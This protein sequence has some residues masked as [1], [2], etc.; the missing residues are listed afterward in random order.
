MFGTFKGKITYCAKTDRGL[1]YNVN[2]DAIAAFTQGSLG[3]F[4][5]SDGMGGHSMGELAS[6]CIALQ[7][8]NYWQQLMS[9]PQLPDFATLTWQVQQVLLQANQMIYAQYNQGQVC[10]ATAVVLLIWEDC[11]AVLSV[12]DSHIYS[13]MDKSLRPLSVDD[14]WDLLPS[15]IS[16]FTPEQ[17]ALHQSRGKLVQAV[18]TKP[19]INIH[20]SSDR[21]KK[22]Q[23]FLLCSDG[24]Y[25]FCDDKQ[26]EKGLRSIKSE[27]S[28]QN[29][30]GEYL[31][32]V[33]DNGAGDNV[34]IILVQVI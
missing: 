13:L 30:M 25:K 27:S 33:F 32:N 16:T 18:G 31:Q 28:M 17:I 7:Y 26:I 20:V 29:V 3:L 19:D 24:L 14:I 10:G 1:R 6:R 22:G 11:Y 8:S 34:S 4:V 21:I 15:T 12:G 2:Q 23:V 5:L 9:L